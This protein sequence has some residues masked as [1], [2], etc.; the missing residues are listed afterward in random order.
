MIK[1]SN[2]MASGLMKAR[3]C[4]NKKDG[5][6]ETK[7][8][9]LAPPPSVKKTYKKTKVRFTRLRCAYAF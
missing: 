1:T 9:S 5:E 2:V 4:Q 6:T 7:I 8:L 3:G